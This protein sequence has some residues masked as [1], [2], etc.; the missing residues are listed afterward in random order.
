[1]GK[2]GVVHGMVLCLPLQLGL[3]AIEK[4]AFGSPST[5]DANFSS[6]PFLYIYIYIYK[7]ICGDSWNKFSIKRWGL[8]GKSGVVHGM[9]LCLPLQL[10]LVAI[11]KGAFGSPSTK[12]ANFSSFPFLYIYMYMWWLLK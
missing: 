2:S 12:D 1:M 9:V 3:V 5:K 8:M 10:G 4:G 11:E 7:Y 6:F